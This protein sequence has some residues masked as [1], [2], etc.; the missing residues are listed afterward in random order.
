MLKHQRVRVHLAILQYHPR[1]DSQTL[2]N[3]KRQARNNLDPAL[4]AHLDAG[5][6]EGLSKGLGGVLVAH[7]LFH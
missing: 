4:A 6:P 3:R 1:D 2:R 7:E 5:V